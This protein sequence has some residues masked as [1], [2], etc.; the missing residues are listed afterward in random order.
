MYIEKYKGVTITHNESKDIFLT[1]L[2]YKKGSINEPL[3]APRLQQIRDKIDEFIVTTKSNKMMLPVL[4]KAKYNDTFQQGKVLLFNCIT[5]EL[6]IECEKGKI[7]KVNQN[8]YNGTPFDGVYLYSKENKALLDLLI[9]KQSEK[10]KIEKD[11]KCILS[12]LIP[13][14]AEHIK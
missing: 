4:F 1:D 8:N 12:K 14:T 13:V 7:E 2:S 5:K 6:H 11:I 10:E 9:K 3:Q